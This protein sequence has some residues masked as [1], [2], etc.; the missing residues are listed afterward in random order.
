MIMTQLLTLMLK[1]YKLAIS[2]WF[3]AACRFEPTCSAD[4]P[5]QRS[6]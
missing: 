5:Y 6:S 3:G 2:P 1:G 4:G